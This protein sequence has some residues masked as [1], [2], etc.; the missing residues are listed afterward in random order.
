[1]GYLLGDEG[2]GYALGLGALRAAARAADGRGPATRLGADVL[3]ELR[4]GGPSE[5]VPWL[6]GGGGRGRE[7]VAALAP[8]VRTA[9]AEGDDIARRLLEEGAAELAAAAAAV[10]RR[11]GLEGRAV[12][13][14]VAGGVLL[15]DAAYRE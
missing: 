1:W 7:E 14:A 4:L 8:L 12:P 2:S 5:L 3:R 10:A 6:H 13:V 9:A 15:G 11:L